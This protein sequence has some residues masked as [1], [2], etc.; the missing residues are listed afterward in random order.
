M[1]K[2][3]PLHERMYGEPLYAELVRLLG[4]A[5]CTYRDLLRQLEPL[6]QR[7]DKRKVDAAV[8]HL[9]TYDKQFSVNPPPL[10]DVKLRS[11]ARKLAWGLLGPPPEHE[12]HAAYK[13]GDRIPL[14]WEKAEP[15]AEEPKPEEP[16]KAATKP[17][18]RPKKQRT[19]K[20]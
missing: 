10:A 2:E 6:Y 18:A 14:P 19:K 15:K 17:K 7:Y 12:W 9:F 11:E 1:F 8:V 13:N 20:E 3:K 5:G 16:P 4:Y